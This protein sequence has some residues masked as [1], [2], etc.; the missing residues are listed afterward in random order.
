MPMPRWRQFLANT[1]TVAASTLVALVL[2][3]VALRVLPVARAP[4]VVPPSDDDP[5]QRYAANTPFTWSLG[6]DFYQ[7][8]HGRTNAQGFVADYDYDAAATTPLLAVVGDSF[9]EALQVPFAQSLT[10]R[11]QSAMGARGRAYAFAQSGA[12]LSQ[13]VA[14]AEHAASRYRPQKLVVVVVAND[15]EQSR[16]AQRR[17]DGMYH[18]HPRPDGGFD[19]K[20]TPPLSPGL[21]E[22]A[23]RNSA[24][25]LYL[26]RNI[27]VLSL[28]WQLGLA[29]AQAAP[30]AEDDAVADWFVAALPKAAALAPRDIVLVVDAVRPQIYDPASADQLMTSRFGQLRSRLMVEAGA[31]GFVVIDLNPAFREAYAREG[32]P[33][34]FPTDAHWNARGHAAA[35]QAIRAALASW[36]PLAP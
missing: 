21:V 29:P 2:L 10:G 35:A 33:L 34:E 32:A 6:W 7:V 17:R 36:P 9:V 23:L 3:E 4:P 5:I 25:A 30:M 8:V 27:G 22:R 18:L 15:F 19:W 11:L 20:L 16:Y 31:Q 24:L 13:Y 26:V 14:Y 1:A 12:P 28:G